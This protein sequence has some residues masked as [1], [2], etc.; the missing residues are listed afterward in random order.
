VHA[1]LLRHLGLE[2]PALLDWVGQLAKGVGELDAG[3]IQLEALCN[4]PVMHLAPR[5]RG[6][7]RWI[8][9]ED[10]RLADAELRL[11]ALDQD[12]AKNIRPGIVCGGLDAR[13]GRP[14]RARID[15]P[16]IPSG[17]Q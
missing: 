8:L 2:A 10:G 5:Q 1:C 3:D 17:E 16:R 4:T 13:G 11:D 9:V 7:D 15:S 14:P 6:L 12:P